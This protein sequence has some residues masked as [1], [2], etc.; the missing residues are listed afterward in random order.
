VRE[1]CGCRGCDARHHDTPNGTRIGCHAEAVAVEGA[2]LCSECLRARKTYEGRTAE[3]WRAESARH[4]DQARE[5]FD[6]CD[7]DGFL[8]QWASSI[9]ARLCEVKAE[10][11]ERGGVWSFVALMEGDRIVSE[12]TVRSKFGTSWLLS[13][14]EAEKFGRT[15]IPTGPTSRVQ[16]RLGLHEGKVERRA[17][18]TIKGSGTGL[19]GAANS[20]VVVVRH[21]SQA[22]VDQA[23]GGSR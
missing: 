14:E 23:G 2:K 21:R 12:R 18:V 22:V 6:R 7:T 10:V 11:A 20:R 19:S 3:E 8:S 15:F 9:T 13:H 17:F 1:R 5:S 16:S 4:S